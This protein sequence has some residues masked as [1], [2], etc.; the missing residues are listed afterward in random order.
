[1]QKCFECGTLNPQWVSVTYGI[2]ICL[3]CS[4]VHRSLGVHLSFVRSVTMDKWKDIELEKMMVSV[5]EVSIDA[6]KALAYYAKCLQPHLSKQLACVIS[7]STYRTWSKV[8]FKTMTHLYCITILTKMI[9]V[10]YSNTKMWF[11]LCKYRFNF[12]IISYINFKTLVIDY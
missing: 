8:R 3:E 9:Y 6:A 11:K 1:M 5:P 10:H 2:W 12:N 7:T 4:G